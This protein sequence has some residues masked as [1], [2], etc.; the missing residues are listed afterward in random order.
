MKISIIGTGYV[1]LVQ[2]A[3][4]ADSGNNVLCMDIDEKK[5]S[6]LKKGAIPIYEPGLEEMVRKNI[7]DGRM[8]FTTNLKSAVNLIICV[9]ALCP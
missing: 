8:E 2:A 7:E 3:C 9:A 5:I 4:F 1:G 6:G